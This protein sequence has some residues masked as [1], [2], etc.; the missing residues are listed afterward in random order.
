MRCAEAWQL[1]VLAL[2]LVS[3]AFLAG[4]TVRR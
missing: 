3:L 4:Y 1:T 2:S